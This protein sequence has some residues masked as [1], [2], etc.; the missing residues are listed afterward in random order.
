M[1]APEPVYAGERGPKELQKSWRWSSRTGWQTVRRWSGFYTELK[2]LMDEHL[3]TGADVSLDAKEVDFYELTVAV[4]AEVGPDG[5]TTDPDSQVLTIWTMPNNDLEKEIWDLPKVRAITNLFQLGDA[6]RF[7]GKVN[8][9]L[10]G[11][12]TWDEIVSAI[13][14]YVLAI[15]PAPPDGAADT[16][17]ELVDELSRGGDAGAHFPLA[18]FVLRREQI[19]PLAASILPDVFGVNEIWTHAA[20]LARENNPPPPWETPAGFYLKRTPTID[21][22]DASRKKIVTEWW[23]TDTY[24]RFIYQSTLHSV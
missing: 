2:A 12:I 5:H 22:L 6:S 14:D 18:Q 21:Q 8:K 3:G 17:G 7:R 9:L 11:E 24:S 10:E 15:T 4:A 13:L 16:L 1:P 23:H 19:A 20:L